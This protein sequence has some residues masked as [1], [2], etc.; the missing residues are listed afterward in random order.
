M[1]DALHYTHVG[2]PKPLL[3]QEMPEGP[4]S[5]LQ[6]L[7]RSST[8][9]L[10]RAEDVRY[11]VEVMSAPLLEKLAPLQELYAP[12]MPYAIKVFH[13]AII[14]VVLVLGMRTEP[15]PKLADLFSPF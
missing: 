8:M 2:A 15:R 10:Q 14:P 13:V 3:H 7:Q 11:Q 6:T 1:T 9:V 4:R 5:L 12:M